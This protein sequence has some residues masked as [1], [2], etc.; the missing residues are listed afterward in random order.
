MFLW[1][2]HASPETISSVYSSVVRHW[3]FILMEEGLISQWYVWVWIKSERKSYFVTSLPG[4][5]SEFEVWALL[6]FS[7]NKEVLIHC[8]FLSKQMVPVF[9][10]DSDMSVSVTGTV[11]STSA[12]FNYLLSK[13]GVVY[14]Y[15][16]TN[17][18]CSYFSIFLFVTFLSAF[19]LS[20]V[21]PRPK[22]SD[23]FFFTLFGRSEIEC[24]LWF[25]N[26]STLRKM[27][28]KHLEE[29]KRQKKHSWNYKRT[30]K[31]KTD[32]GQKID[33]QGAKETVKK[34][35]KKT[36]KEVPA[37]PIRFHNDTFL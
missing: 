17:L 26:C 10:R 9:V 36:F 5:V 34:K 37:D 28:R 14:V 25:C 19:A 24:A 21:S 8:R 29:V 1:A 15:F 12:V 35:K 32:F 20:A 11:Q 30:P 16:W 6:W 22:K 31:A 33:M 27:W 23:I 2:W 7:H 4:Q 3:F 18:C 13:C